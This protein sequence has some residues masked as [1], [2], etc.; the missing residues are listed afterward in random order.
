MLM[1]FKNLIETEI[2]GY[3]GGVGEDVEN[4]KGRTHWQDINESDWLQTSH[5]L[6]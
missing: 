6:Q 2:G 4:E 5:L 3:F 1:E